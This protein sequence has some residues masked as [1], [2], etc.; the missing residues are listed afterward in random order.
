[1]ACGRDNVPCLPAT[2]EYEYD[3]YDP[4]SLFIEVLETNLQHQI[5]NSHRCSE[6]DALDILPQIPKKINSPIAHNFEEVG[7]GMRAITGFVLWKVVL[8]MIVSQTPAMGFAAWWLYQRP[9]DLQ[10]ALTPAVLILGYLTIILVIP[11]VKDML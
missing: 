2:T 8:A 5:Q 1:V 6:H 4:Q 9:W 11:D 7:Y 3:Y 10:N